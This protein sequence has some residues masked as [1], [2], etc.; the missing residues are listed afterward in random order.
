MSI[1]NAILQGI[2]QGLTE[3]LP[4]SSD[5]HLTLFQHFT[6]TSGSGAMLFTVMLHMGTLIAV[7]IAYWKQIWALILEFFRMVKDIFTGKFSFK[8]LNP[9]RRMIIMIVVAT[10]PLL[11]FYFVKDYFTALA[12]DSDIVVEGLLFIFTGVLLFMADRCSKGTKTAADMKYGDS[13]LIGAFQGLAALPAVSRSGSTISIALMRGY[14]REYAVMF[15]FILGIPAIL[16]ANIFEVKD[17]LQAGMTINLLPA[18]IG[19]VCAAVVGY[20]A[21]KLIAWLVK[22]DRFVIFAYYTFIL[23]VLTIIVGTIEHVVGMNFVDYIASV[24]K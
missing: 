16:G 7:F 10:L 23:G 9:D 15:S 14:T 19:I 17:A 21:I 12:E 8:N 2:L 1:F 22:T 11:A 24:I 13:L 18:V 5:G 3:F 4:V 6:G 20:F